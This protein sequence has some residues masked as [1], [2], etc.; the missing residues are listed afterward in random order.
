[1][2]LIS[3]LSLLFFEPFAMC[4][5]FLLTILKGVSITRFLFVQGKYFVAIFYQGE[6]L[7]LTLELLHINRLL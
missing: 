2:D 4:L 5:L 7:K 1:M 6:V 3:V